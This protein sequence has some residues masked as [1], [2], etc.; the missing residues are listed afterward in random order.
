MELAN[1]TEGWKEEKVDKKTGDIV[2]SRK[3]SGGRKIYRCRAKIEMPAKLLIEKISDTDHVTEWNT[4]LTDAKVL[5][6][7]ND[8]CAISY[9]VIFSDLNNVAAVANCIRVNNFQHSW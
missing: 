7:L 6:K 8:D 9:Q 5:K 3:N 2:E 1:L 4:T